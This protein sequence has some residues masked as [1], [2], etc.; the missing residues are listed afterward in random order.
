MVCFL[1]YRYFTPGIPWKGPGSIY[2][3]KTLTQNYYWCLCKYV[4]WH[5]IHTIKVAGHL[6]FSLAKW[7]QSC[8]HKEL[9][10]SF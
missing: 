2:C 5:F 7:I 8:W 9:N 4:S 3:S 1:S 10:F 6:L